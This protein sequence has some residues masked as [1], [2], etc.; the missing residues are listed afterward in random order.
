MTGEQAGMRA[1]VLEEVG[2]ANATAT[3]SGKTI[4][5]RTIFYLMICKDHGEL[6]TWAE[7][8]WLPYAKLSRKLQSKRELAAVKNAKETLT[9]LEKAKLLKKREEDDQP[10][11]LE[12]E[13]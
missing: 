13:G 1:K 10:P 7:A 4:P 12:T 5:Q 9:Q 2:R 6:L 8:D 3:V 11:E